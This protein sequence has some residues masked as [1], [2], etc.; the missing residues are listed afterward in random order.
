MTRRAFSPALQV[1][2]LEDRLNPAGTMIPA[3]QF[4]WMQ[5]SPTGEL[6]ELVWNGNALVYRDR[7]AGAWV[8]TTITT[9]N[10]FTSAQ[11]NSE[12]SVEEASRTAQLVFTSDGTPHALVLDKVWNGSAGEYQTVIDDF[13]RTPTG[14]QQVETITP[15][16]LSQWGP[17]TLVAVAG[18]NDAI[19]LVFT[20]T[21]AAATGVGNVGSGALYYATDAGGSWAFSKIATTADLNQDVWFTGGRWAPRFI[22]LAVDAHNNAYVT[23]T[24]EFYIAGAFSTVDSTLMYATN[25][26]GSWA[27]Q[28][29]QAPINGGPADAGLGASIAVSPTGQVAIASY[30]VQRYSTG[31]AEDS[32]LMY[33]T[34]V[35]GQWTTSVVTT[36]PAGYVA[37]DGAKFTGFA[38]DLSFNAAG[39]PVI[40]FEDEAS[41]HL[42]VSYD[43]E[44]AGQIRVATLNGSTWSF[45]TV[46]AQT[47]PIENQLYY[48][49]SATYGGKTVYAGLDVTTTVDSNLNPVGS[50]YALVD[51]NAPYG[52]A[53]PPV[54]V[55]P[56][57]A[58][59]APATAVAQS[60]PPAASPPA[61]PAAVQTPASPVGYAVV[62]QTGTSPTQVIVYRPDGSV[63]MVVTPFGD[64][65]YGTVRI[66]RGDVL[67]N[68]TVDLITVTGPGVQARLR[69][70]DGNTG[71]LLEDIEVFPGFL[72]GLWVAAGDMLDAGYDDIAVGADEG[73]EPHVD[74]FDGR[75]QA[76]LAS[77]FAYAPGFV[78]GVRVAMGDV[79][80]DGYADIVTAPGFGAG[81]HVTVFDGKALADG[82]GPVHDADFFMYDPSMI[83]GIEIAVADI[84][85]NG[86]ADII[87]GPSDGS[88]N[89]RIVSGYDLMTGQGAVDLT[90][91]YAWPPDGSGMHV[92]VSDA[93]GT[94]TPDLIVSSSN[95]DNGE[96]GVLT[97][98]A[99]LSN[100]PATIQWLDPLPGANTSVYVG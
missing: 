85:G 20:E 29:V 14:W 67:G 72:G 42:P 71:A 9:T 61:A 62:D 7:V 3:G 86:Y 33:H 80:D 70:W 74:V 77:F 43:N 13:A 94:G 1:E 2:Q 47:N 90:S 69:V 8:D 4:N 59:P 35:N 97:P 75:S 36:T 17:N 25:A 27:S 49:V 19:D 24:P 23:Y 56:P 89:L 76:I 12:S 99:L 37:A 81:A 34:L 40:V 63:Q 83:S 64:S 5:Y 66:A 32:E 46:L 58:V 21:S 30:Y 95:P 54:T 100:S 68:G 57:V 18:P 22:S 45:Q 48:P 82:E 73:L 79:N 26:G 52:S 88:S 41:Q 87:A 91:M 98:A 31:S 51:V 38:P 39:E 55:A 92:A 6:A 96:I 84:S 44:Y 60:P 50:T 78:G 93:F 53:S 28:V 15:N 10:T 11:Y 16:W 65:Y